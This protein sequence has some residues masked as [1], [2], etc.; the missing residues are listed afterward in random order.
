[1]LPGRGKWKWGIGTGILLAC[2]LCWSPINRALFSVRFVWSMHELASGAT[3]KNLA[4]R[5]AKIN[6]RSAGQ[7]YEALVYSPANSAPTRAV[8]LVAGLSELG[9]YHPSLVAL[10]RFLADR[11]L[12]VITPD[13]REFRDFQITAKPIDQ[14]LFWY[15]HAPSLDGG[16]KVQKTGLA[17]ISYSGTIALIA[18]ARREVRNTIGFV[19]AVGPY[20]SLIRCTRNWFAAAPG[21]IEST[22]YPTR[23]YAKWIIMLSALDM[24]AEP[25][26]RI[27]LR[28]VLDSLL[29]QKKVPPANPDLT[30]E[31]ARW[32]ALA[33][34]PETR[35]DP[36]LTTRIEEHLISSIYPQIDPEEALSKISCPVFLIHGAYDDLMPPAESVELHQKIQIP[37]C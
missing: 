12:M 8:I 9:C 30:A 32:Y 24:V 15:R 2:I 23:F 33:T 22:G 31:G 19:V 1:M 13:I 28:E 36:E 7:D 37:A 3:G 26:D 5:E 16:E 25:K 6:R 18:A 11:G 20:S 27:F 21:S 14:I 34:M 17:G 4:I 29:L 10:A 35:S